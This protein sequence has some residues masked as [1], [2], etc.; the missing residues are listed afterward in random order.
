MLMFILFLLGI[1]IGSFLNV[2]IYRIPLT[3]SIVTA[4]SFCPH[5][6]APV[7]PIH[8][9][10]VVGYLMLGGKCAQCRE[11]ISGRYPIVETLTGL[12][13]VTS[14]LQFGLT[15]YGSIV[16]TLVCLLIVISYIDID[17]FIIPDRMLIISFFLWLL[18]MGT[19]FSLENL[20]EAF[21]GSGLFAGFLYTSRGLGKLLFKKEALGLGDVKLAIVLGAFL[22]WE[23]TIV[24]L[25]TAFLMAAIYSI[26]GLM[27]KKVSFGQM[28]PFGPFLAMG[29][30]ISIFFGEEILTLFMK[31]IV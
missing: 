29:S 14:F 12:I 10:P 26:A 15:I 22:G 3:K 23:M 27:N 6:E 5:C 1:I 7:K 13:A 30:V 11:A 28:L 16:F 17:H 18:F 31:W 21:I 4:A 9:L 20:R 19:N 8:N 24:S 25:Y 2:C